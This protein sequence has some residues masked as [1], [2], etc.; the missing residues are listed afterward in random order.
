[1][2]AG[3]LHSRVQVQEP[4]EVRG[5]EGDITTTWLTIGSRW[6]HVQPQEGRRLEQAQQTQVDVLHHVR[7]R[8]DPQI[9]HRHRLLLGQYETGRTLNILAVRTLDERKTEMVLTCV[10]TT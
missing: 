9:T 5:D 4:I 2:N 3:A 7:M 10:E 6:A 8:Y 1:M